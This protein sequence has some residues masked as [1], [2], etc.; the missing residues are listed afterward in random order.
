MSPF[1]FPEAPTLPAEQ[2]ASGEVSTRYEDIAQDGRVKLAALPH[3]IGEVCWMKLLR[4]H[5][6][7]RITRTE[8]IVPI[9]SRLVIEGGAGPVSV[10]RW[11]EGEGSYQLAHTAADDGEVNRLILNLWVDVYGRAGRTHGPPP[12]NAGERLRVG[13]VY[14]EHVFTRPFA[15][16]EQRKVQSFAGIEGMPEV[17]PDRWQWRDPRALLEVPPGATALDEELV[18]DPL[19]TVFGLMH[20]DSNQHV[21]SLEYPRIFE[22]AALRRLDAH[23]KHGERLVRFVELAYRK[24]CFAGDRVRVRLRA[25][26]HEGSAGA[27]AELVPARDGSGRPYCFARLAF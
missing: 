21:N 16:T 14:A 3:A 12:D 26:D 5:A 8:G 22:E 7:T 15:P 11:L 4:H 2:R 9:L 19:E 27:V 23:G 1:S 20:T 24:P 13:R 6:I 18:N 25:F 17:P 10:R